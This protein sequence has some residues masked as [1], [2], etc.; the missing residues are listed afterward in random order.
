MPS[1]V[2]PRSAIVPDSEWSAISV[3][4]F[5]NAADDASRR[6]LLPYTR[7]RWIENKLRFAVDGPANKR[8]ESM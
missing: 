6:Q 4:P 8:K 5:V 7:S 3:T 1:E 2:Y